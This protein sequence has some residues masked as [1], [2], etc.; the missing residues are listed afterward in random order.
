M[1]TDQG[2]TNALPPEYRLRHPTDDDLPA[3]QSLADE[4]DSADCG[5][6][7]VSDWNAV[8]MAGDPNACPDQNWWVFE[9]GAGELAGLGE[10]YTPATGEPRGFVFVSPRHSGRGLAAHLFRMIETRARELAGAAPD[11]PP[12]LFMQCE[13]TQAERQAWLLA[14]GYRRVREAFA[15]RIDLGQGAGAPAWPSGI[16][17]RDMRLHVDD[18]ALCDAENDAFSEHF[19]YFP[20]TI[21]V[22]R[23]WTYGHAELD[24]SLWP[25]AW[26][27]DEVAGQ[28]WGMPVGDGAVIE[29]VMVRKP[30]R[31]RGLALAL[32]LEVFARLHE[33]GRDDVILWVDAE[34]TT[35]AVRLYEAAGM[36]VWRHMSIFKLDLTQG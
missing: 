18:E 33:R 13:D 10:L 5:E 9:D 24:P 2:P 8:A 6:R 22:W 11:A 32:L 36:H 7:R 27:A 35:G 15:M 3:I 16:A 12:A 26:D 17:V 28:V 14:H 34:N 1:S 20:V 23:A 30:W 19:L 21:D 31:G 4:C 29:V 25:V